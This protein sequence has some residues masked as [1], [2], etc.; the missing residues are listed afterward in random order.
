MKAFT[1]LEVEKGDGL[2]G[3]AAEKGEI[4]KLHPS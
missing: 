2:K 4:I 3:E 1:E